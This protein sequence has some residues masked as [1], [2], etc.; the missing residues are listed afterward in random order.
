MS[1]HSNYAE[2]VDRTERNLIKFEK[3]FVNFKSDFIEVAKKNHESST[4][5]SAFDSYTFVF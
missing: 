4:H 5:D 2:E 3:D 1:G